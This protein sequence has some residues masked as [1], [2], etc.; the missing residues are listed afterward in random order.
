MIPSMQK[1]GERKGGEYPK[2]TSFNQ[3]GLILNRKE[4]NT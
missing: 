1:I 2:H 3:H 4:E